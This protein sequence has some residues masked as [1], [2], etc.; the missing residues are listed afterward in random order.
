MGID[1]SSVYGLIYAAE[2]GVKFKDTLTIGRQQY[3]LS[4]AELHKMLKKYIIIPPSV[5]AQISDT[6]DGT[7]YAEGLFKYF[8]AESVDSIDYS[9]YEGATI[10]HNMNIAIE[11]NLKNRFSCVLDGGSLEHIFIYSTALKNCMDMVKVNG[12]LILETPANNYFGHGFYQFS[13]ELFFSV[14]CE[15]NGFAETKIFMQDD[16]SR[17]YEVISPKLLKKR[18]STCCAR[19]N[20]STMLVISKKMNDVPDILSV[21]QSDYIDIWNG[22]KDFQLKVPLIRRLYHALVPE[23]VRSLIG[24]ARHRRLNE[25]YIPLRSFPY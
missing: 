6:V 21:L 9:D 24:I 4:G 17:W 10:I 14:L 20:S 1:K 22:N 18:V 8:G 11:D 23:K 3:F 25:F 2:H 16:R 7:N 12:H 19:N 5:N 15:Q 13:P